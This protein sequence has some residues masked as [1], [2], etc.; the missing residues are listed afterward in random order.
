MSKEN[1]KDDSNGQL[2]SEVWK[3]ALDEKQA[4][5]EKKWDKV[6]AQYED[7]MEERKL[8]ISLQEFDED[9]QKTYYHAFKEWVYRHKLYFLFARSSSGDGY[10]VALSPF[11]LKK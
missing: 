2:W 6:L 5:L 8:V 10:C 9:I 4:E 7:Q 11:P 3:K 1:S